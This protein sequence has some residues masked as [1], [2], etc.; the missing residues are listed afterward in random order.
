MRVKLK[1]LNPKAVVPKY[2]K[3]GDA[4]VDLVAIH[5]WEDEKG[6][7]CY[8]TGLAMEIP[9]DHAAFIFPRSS[10]SK[11]DVRLSNCVGIIDSGYRGEIIVKFDKKG[12]NH[13]HIG[14]RVAQLMILRVP[15]IWFVEVDDLQDSQRG[16]G[17]FGSSGN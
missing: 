16:S 12:N 5:K 15:D 4:A 1:K 13:Y 9:L 7:L 8:G 17:G 14:D 3:F 2:A 6:N 11:M 10:I